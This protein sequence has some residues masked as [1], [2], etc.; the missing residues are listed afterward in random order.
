ME[1]GF[2]RQWAECDITDSWGS[3]V[4]RAATEKADQREAA[5]MAESS[6]L[7]RYVGLG[8]EAADGV[9]P[10]LQDFS[11]REGTRLM[12]KC[13]LN[14]LM[15]VERV[16]RILKWPAAGANVGCMTRTQLRA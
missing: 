3:D 7:V 14:Y 8:H 12:T 2:T 5:E 4:C 11:N 16:A 1:H 10:Y 9:P 13:R 6:S 15:L